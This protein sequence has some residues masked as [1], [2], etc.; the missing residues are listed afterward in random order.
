MN[1]RKATTE[2][3]QPQ[4]GWCNRPIKMCPERTPEGMNGFSNVLSGQNGFG[5][6]TRRVVP[7]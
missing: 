6:P 3:S 2:I 4:S 5:R 1:S 7:G